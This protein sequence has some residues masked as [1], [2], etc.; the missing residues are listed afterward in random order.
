MG[1]MT[2]VVV[3]NCFTV[4]KTF[5]FAVLLMVDDEDALTFNGF[6][7]TVGAAKL[8][9][10]ATALMVIDFVADKDGLT[11]FVAALETARYGFLVAGKEEFDLIV[12]KIV[13]C[14][15]YWYQITVST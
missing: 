11:V 1:R 9:M 4:G 6:I 15:N 8:D 13:Y 7:V 5:T 14:Y 2:F 10:L 12:I 3:G